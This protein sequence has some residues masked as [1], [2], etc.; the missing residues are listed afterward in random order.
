MHRT[1]YLYNVQLKGTTSVAERTG[2]TSKRP[3]LASSLFSISE[4][5]SEQQC[6]KTERDAH[7]SPFFWEGKY[8][9]PT[10]NG[11]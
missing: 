10:R 7:I 6:V 9:V 3:S 8:P 5:V 1:Q 2:R 4:G 11:V